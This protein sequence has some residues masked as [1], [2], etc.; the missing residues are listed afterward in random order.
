MGGMF[1]HPTFFFKIGG[2]TGRTHFEEFLA[3]RESLT[4]KPPVRPGVADLN[5]P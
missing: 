4:G 3:W 2:I 5:V 1:I